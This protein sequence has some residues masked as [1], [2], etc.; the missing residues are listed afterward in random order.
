MQTLTG[1]VIGALALTIA[2]AVAP[3]PASAQGMSEK[4][5]ME[6]KEK[7]SDPAAAAAIHKRRLAMRTMGGQTKVVAA[8]LKEGK[9]TPADVAAAGK[10]IASI[11][12][13]IPDL[14]PAGTGLDKYP[15][16]TGA[17]PVVWEKAGD[18]KAAA[19]ELGKHAEELVKVASAADAG[20]AGI[21]AA[22]GAVGKMGCGGCHRTYKQ[23]LK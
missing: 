19:M 10:K 14:F 11:A 8:Y 4:L 18:F 12:A 9:G 13:T 15:G 5:M 7:V 17:K 2:A 23:D 16:A 1:L 21:G 22:F 6:I 20:K 3:A